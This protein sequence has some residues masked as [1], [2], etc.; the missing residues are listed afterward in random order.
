MHSRI[1]PELIEQARRQQA[2][3]DC[4]CQAC[5]EK[6]DKLA[7]ASTHKDIP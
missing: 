2:P 6:A 1:K 4:I 7:Y 3:R 5:A